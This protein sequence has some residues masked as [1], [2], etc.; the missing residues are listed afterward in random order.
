MT[1]F[2][3]ELIF[4]PNFQ[5]HFQMIKMKPGNLNFLRVLPKEK[6]VMKATVRKVANSL[7]S[8][9]NI[10][11]CA[12]MHTYQKQLVSGFGLHVGVLS[13]FLCHLDKTWSHQRGSNLR[14]ANDYMRSIVRHCLN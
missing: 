7:I 10:L 9:T 14:G 12:K 13:G 1:K 2:T 5:G 6:H 8:V 4:V 11:S 3:Q